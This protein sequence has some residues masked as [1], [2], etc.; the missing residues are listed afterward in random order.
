MK[1][2]ADPFD[3]ANETWNLEKLYRDLAE[4]KRQYCG[5]LK[6]LTPV[7]MA[8]LRGLLCGFS[9][10]E[11]AA[12][13]NREPRGLRVDLSR[14]LYRYVEVLT[15]RE[16][17]QLKDWRD[18]ADWLSAYQTHSPIADDSAIKIV[19]IALGGSSQIPV[20][21]VKVRNVG[22]Q[23][24]F[25]KK[26]KFKFY[27]T[28]FLYSWIPVVEKLAMMREE[29]APKS[30]AYAPPAARSR[31]VEPSFDYE[32]D[33]N[34][35]DFE[36]L[37]LQCEQPAQTKIAPP[38]SGRVTE[39]F[40]ISQCVGCNDVDRFTLSLIFPPEIPQ[41]CDFG[42]L[43]HVYHLRLEII[44]DEDD[45]VAESQNLILGI[46]ADSCLPLRDR[47]FFYTPNQRNTNNLQHY[48]AQNQITLEEIA[49]IK[50]LQ[51]RILQQIYRHPS[52]PE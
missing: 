33:L 41:T 6:K 34:I 4:A 21:D 26:A 16:A 45:K 47:C 51:N 38:N 10:P 17:N 27:K 23:V 36:L 5:K 15:Q 8:C 50:G 40:N 44:Y 19:D 2:F 39:E 9:P 32:V 52:L 3:R 18:V 1:F 37:E 48:S 42:F 12:E 31:A 22:Q 14:G 49:K 43:T 30:E 13:L 20:L 35:I 11:I 7:E 24:A 25:L 29:A 28:W 46:E